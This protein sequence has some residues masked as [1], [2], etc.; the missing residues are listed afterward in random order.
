MRRNFARG[1]TSVDVATRRE[2]GR[3]RRVSTSN[4]SVSGPRKDKQR[5]LDTVDDGFLDALERPRK[6]RRRAEPW[7]PAEDSLGRRP[8]LTSANSTNTIHVGR[9]SG[10]FH[11]R[12]REGGRR[13]LFLLSP[14]VPVDADGVAAAPRLPRG[15]SQRKQKVVGIRSSPRRGLVPC[16]RG[17]SETQPRRRRDAPAG[18]QRNRG[19]MR[20]RSVGDASPRPRHKTWSTAV[21]HNRDPAGRLDAVGPRRP[22]DDPLRVSSVT[23]AHDDKKGPVA[24]PAHG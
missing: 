3:P 19:V 15:E 7:R 23:R 8:S 17:L 14:E 9:P 6:P 5:G 2:D 12:L 1:L 11:V 13:R 4:L 20:P 16:I 10:S 22:G 24:R 18:H 21:A